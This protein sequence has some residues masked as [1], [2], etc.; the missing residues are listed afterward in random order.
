M[1]NIIA[2]FKFK[3]NKLKIIYYLKAINIIFKI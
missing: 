2:L 3:V 1:Y